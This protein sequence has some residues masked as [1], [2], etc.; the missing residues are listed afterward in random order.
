[1]TWVVPPEVTG[2][3]FRMCFFSVQSALGC[4]DEETMQICALTF[5][6]S[7]ADLLFAPSVLQ[8]DDAVA[9]LERCDWDSVY[10]E[11]RTLKHTAQERKVFLDEYTE[12]K[13]SI[14]AAALK[15]KGKG[16]G[17]GVVAVK[18]IPSNIPQAS[19]KR[20]L[21]PGASIWVAHK[22]SR[23][24]G[25]LPPRKRCGSAFKDYENE[26]AAAKNTLKMLWQQYA[27]LSAIPLTELVEFK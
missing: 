22:K 7:D 20:Y 13:K 4:T 3:Y 21:P 18:V 17:K 26:A 10:T 25:H 19:L 14:R 24:E 23:W 5:G 11:Q 12:R 1:M 6:T 15:G 27:E 8:L 2:S 9:L 16:K